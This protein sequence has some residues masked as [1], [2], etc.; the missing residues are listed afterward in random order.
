M[1]GMP[2]V[3]QVFAAPKLSNAILL[4]INVRKSDFGVHYDFFVLDG[5]GGGSPFRCWCDT[6]Y[7]WWHGE[8]G[9]SA[10][11]RS[12]GMTKALR[13]FEFARIA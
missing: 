12:F 5:G 3:G 10:F 1:I 6:K 11:N 7:D 13:T 9:L 8:I 2:K 4:C